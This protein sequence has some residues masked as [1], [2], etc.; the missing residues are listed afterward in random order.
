MSITRLRNKFKLL[1]SKW[2][3]LHS[4]IK[5]GSGLARSNEPLWFKHM[6]FLVIPVFSE[7]NAKIRLSSS[8]HESSF[9]QEDGESDVCDSNE[10]DSREDT[11]QTYK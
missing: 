4:H 5:R 1:K 9:V 8:A 6:E 11:I 3:K 10:E 2:C 7:T